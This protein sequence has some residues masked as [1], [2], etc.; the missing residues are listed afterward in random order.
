MIDR[1]TLTPEQKQQLA[2]QAKAV[3]NNPAFKMA[4]DMIDQQYFEAWKKSEPQEQEG[5]ERL[6]MAVHVKDTLVANLNVILGD[7]M[8]SRAAIDRAKG[9]KG[10]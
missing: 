2:D 10:I 4:S 1:N 6:Y 9:K 7:G 8:L 3:L 5:R